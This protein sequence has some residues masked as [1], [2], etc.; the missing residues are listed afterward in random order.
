MKIKSLIIGII[1][2]ATVLP[3]FVLAAPP[4]LPH[5]FYGDVTNGGVDV[6]IDTVIIAKVD[7]VE[8]GRITASVAGEYGGPNA[9]DGKLLVQGSLSSTDVVK[10][11]IGDNVADQEVLFS[12]GVVRNLDLTFNV[13][14][15]GGGGGGGSY[16]L[17]AEV[18]ATGDMNGDNIVNKF[19]FALMMSAWGKTGTGLAADLN[20]DGKVDKY[21]FAL[22][23]LNWGK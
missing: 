18:Y 23:M 8:K 14:A 17:P 2:A 3:V 19:D 6:P 7:G 11:Y 5:L 10:F 9:L 20:S 13:P 21:D 15:S 4:Q 16:T 22:L 12:T 1:C